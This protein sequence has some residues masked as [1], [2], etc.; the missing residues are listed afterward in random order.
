MTS[1]QDT[2][3]VKAEI[4]PPI[5]IARVGNS[6]DGFYLGPEVPD[7]HPLPPGSYRDDAG[8]LKR[9]AAR[10]RLYGYNAAGEVVAELTA[11]NADIEWRATLANTKAAWYQF[12][13]ALDIPDAASAPPS[14][15]R[16]MAIADRSVLSI[17]PGERK[18]SGCEQSGAPYQFANGLFMG[19]EVYLGELRT[20]AQGRLIVLGGHGRSASYNGARAITFANN[21]GW[22]DDVADG[23]VGATVRIGGREVPVIPAWVVVAPPNYAPQ[24]KSVRTMW[25]LMRDLFVS[26]GKLAAPASPSFQDDIRP[27]FERLSRLQWVNAGFAAAF[28]WGGSTPF[29]QAE[30]M[31][32]LANPAEELKEWRRTLYNQFRNFKRDAWAPS[33]WPWLY[34]DAMAIP[35]AE[36]PEQNA[37]LSTLQLKFLEQWADGNFIADYRPDAV[38]PQRVEDV[39]LAQQ[40]DTLTR[41]AMEFC[42]ADAFHP[43]CEMTW[44]MRQKTMYMAPFRLAHRPPN[45]VEPDYGGVLTHDNYSS[46]CGAQIA[47]G[48]SRWMAVPWQTDTASCRSG[49]QKSYDPYVPTFWPAR[50]PN[51]VL[52]R[53]NYEIV[54]DESKPKEE[55]LRA[56][57]QRAAWIRPL[58][59][60]SYEEQINNMIAD[61]SQM[62]VV[63]VRE[64]PKDGLR[65][66]P[67]MEVEELP[68]PVPREGLLHAAAVPEEFEDIDIGAIEKARHLGGRRHT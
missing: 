57:A 49:Y 20:D 1:P 32:R 9:E 35:P 58:G 62:G 39:P 67:V 12:Q 2:V 5:G 68:K 21:E 63:E 13:I 65:L 15:L 29:S 48:I 18:I 14:F 40:P 8:K 34:G 64:G 30:W 31:A 33:P 36:T 54:I 56:F 23:P 59:S 19:E 43:G 26:E 55:R 11:D 60:I 42:L 25:D 41:A 10:F 51:Q 4:Y 47:G 37:A 46:T 50:V 16:N 53:H 17:T 6:P 45:W 66:P 27:I 22:Y 61:I 7:P 52:S 38:P 3:I 44:P 28:G 24:Q